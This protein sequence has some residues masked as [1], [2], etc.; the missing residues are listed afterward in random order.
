MTEQ[1]MNEKLGEGRMDSALF[2]C[3]VW[4]MSNGTEIVNCYSETAKEAFEMLGYW[5]CSIFEDG[6][7]LEY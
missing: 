4:G 2:H 7:M 1:E 3:T 5:V 6:I